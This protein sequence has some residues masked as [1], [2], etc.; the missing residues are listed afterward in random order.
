MQA[1]VDLQVRQAENRLKVKRNVNS[2]SAKVE[3]NSSEAEKTAE[4]QGDNII[5]NNIPA[6]VIK[7]RKVDHPKN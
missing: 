6:M 5:L 1:K 4:L 3:Q 2:I 7:I